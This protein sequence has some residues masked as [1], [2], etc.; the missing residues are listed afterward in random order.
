[1]NKSRGLQGLLDSTG[2]LFFCVF[3][4]QLEI[5]GPWSL[6]P[7]TEINRKTWDLGFPICQRHLSDLCQAE[8]LLRKA[9]AGREEQLGAHPDT[10]S[11][12][13]NLAVILK[14]QGK[15]EEAP[16]SLGR[17]GSFC[18]GVWRGRYFF[19]WASGKG[20]DVVLFPSLLG[21]LV[22]GDLLPIEK[23]RRVYMLPHEESNIWRLSLLK[24]YIFLKCFSYWLLFPIPPGHVLAE[25]WTFHHLP[26]IQKSSPHLK[27][28]A[29]PSRSHIAEQFHEDQWDMGVSI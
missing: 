7:L 5:T 29:W 4:H 26:P 21:I 8:E 9:L 11:S 22:L 28:T 18:L 20:L 10:L 2:T 16:G 19:G 24:Y 13:N 17:E 14:Q 12:M 1:M 15:L 23:M 27:G 3:V 25:C 6:L